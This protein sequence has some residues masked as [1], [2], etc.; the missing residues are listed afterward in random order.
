MIYGAQMRNLNHQPTKRSEMTGNS[1]AL[2]NNLERFYLSIEGP[3]GHGV[4]RIDRPERPSSAGL[5]ER[6]RLK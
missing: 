6:Q 3:E 2:P 4:L 1:S 5:N